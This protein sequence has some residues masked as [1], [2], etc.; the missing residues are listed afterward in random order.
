MKSL[1]KLIQGKS[2]IEWKMRA[3]HSIEEDTIELNFQT[4]SK[5]FCFLI[6]KDATNAKGKRKKLNKYHLRNF[7][8]FHKP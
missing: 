4:G 8:L 5:T 2:S 1:E 6:K 3:F 7:C